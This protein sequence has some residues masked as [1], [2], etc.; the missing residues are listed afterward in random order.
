MRF[1]KVPNHTW[2]VNGWNAKLQ[3]K[4]SVYFSIDTMCTSQDIL[5]GFD[6]AEIDIDNIVSI[7]RKNSTRLWI[8][9]FDTIEAKNKALDIG[10][11]IVSDC[12]V[13]LGDSDHQLVLV[14]IHEAPDKI[15][16]TVVIDRLSYY[17]R[18]VSFR[19]DRIAAGIFNG[20]RTA[21]VRLRE[22]IPP[23]VSIAGEPFRI[24]Y[25]SQPKS[26]KK[27]GSP[28]HMAADCKNPRCYNCD[29]HGHRA[30][31]C[32]HPPLCSICLSPSHPSTG[33]PFLLYSANVEQCDGPSF[34]DAARAPSPDQAARE[35][36]KA[37]KDAELKARKEKEKKEK[38]ARKERDEQERARE[39]ERKEKERMEEERLAQERERERVRQEEQDRKDFEEWKRQ[40]EKERRRHR[41]DY[42]HRKDRHREGDIDWSS[43]RD[44]DRH[45][46][47]FDDDNWQVVRHRKSR[48]R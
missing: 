33:C 39:K 34:A 48:Y 41:D 47:D 6:K 19:R 18:I 5:E 45:S 40:K 22:N 11:V 2:S 7:Q 37:K 42:D 29:T 9:S 24:W 20:I 23:V 16:D 46:D 27:C 28:D 30:N 14:K 8:V 12:Q 26:C 1:V 43:R 13:F 4:L 36:A 21:R 44:H 3:K 17:S 38:K 25:N 35:E 15:P 32:H 10:T 31:D